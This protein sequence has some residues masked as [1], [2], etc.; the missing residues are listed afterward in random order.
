VGEPVG[1]VVELVREPVTVRFAADQL[2]DVFNGTVRALVCR[3]EMDLRAQG[4]EDFHPLLAHR[5][6]HGEQ[7]AVSFNC[8]HQCEAYARIS[9]GGLQDDLIRGQFPT[10]FRLLDHVQG[11]TVLDRATRVE[12]LEFGKDFH[13]PVGVHAPH[14]DHGGVP[15]LL[16]YVPHTVNH[17]DLLRSRGLGAGK[18][19]ERAV[20]HAFDSSVRR[21]IVSAGPAGAALGVLRRPLFL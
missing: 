8:G 3:S 7:D 11:G 9:T 10:P 14:G 21:K 1:L 12:V 15:Y 4:P 20:S 19:R 5:L 18:E 6:G 13:L 2:V 17:D 16:E